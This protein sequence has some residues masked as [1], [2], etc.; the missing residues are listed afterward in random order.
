LKQSNRREKEAISLEE[1]NR[2]DILAIKEK[3][4][5]YAATCNAGDLERWISLWTDDGIQMPPSAPARV[6]KEQIRA[7]MKTAFDQY[8]IKVTINNEETRVSGNLGFARGIGVESL[9]PK[10]GGKT[11]KFDLKYL[12]IFEKQT[13]GS[14][15]IARDCFNSN[16]PET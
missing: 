11:E 3:L 1:Q 8:I 2:A 9:I 16:V 4:N 7:G 5:E 13:N 12:T 15:K 6:G 14:W 10:A